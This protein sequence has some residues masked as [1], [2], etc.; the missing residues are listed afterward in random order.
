MSEDLDHILANSF[1]DFHAKGLDYLCLERSPRRTVK[2]YFFD[3]DVAESPEAVVPHDHRYDFETTC[4]AGSVVNHAF[5]ETARNERGLQ[6][7]ERFDY[8]TPLNGGAG[9]TWRDT[10]QLWRASSVR[11]E[12]GAAYHM[13]ASQIHTISVRPDTVLRLVQ[14]A[15]SVPLD[16]PTAAYRPAG[17]REAPSLDGL[18]RPM[19]ADHALMR[20]AQYR[21]LAERVQE[22]A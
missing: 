12:P 16:A 22:A 11:Y 18:Y 1:R 3:G 2:V 21:R 13:V 8:L 15:D 19:D 5:F 20:L 10:V 17:M 7:Y 4:L 6:T 14:Y 9:F